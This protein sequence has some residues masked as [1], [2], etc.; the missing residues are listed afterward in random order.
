M[1]TYFYTCLAAVSLVL[2]SCDPQPRSDKRL[3]N[4]LI[5][6]DTD[7]I[8][9]YLDAGGDV[10]KPI[11]YQHY[12]VVEAPMLDIAIRNGH[13]NLVDLLLRKG[14]DPNQKDLHGETPLLW[15]LGRTVLSVPPETRATILKMLLHAKADPNLGDGPPLLWTPLCAAAMYGKHDMAKIL[16]A[17]GA[18]VNETN[19]YGDTAM[20]FADDREMAQLLL[21][22]GADLSIYGLKTPAEVARRNQRWDVYQLLTNYTAQTNASIR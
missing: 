5:S 17:S 8:Q 9:R 15:V 21:D 16:L 12:D 18:S 14:A 6:N 1:K 11:R 7:F 3:T 22:A 13:T 2:M 10:N 19:G 20:Y 4:A